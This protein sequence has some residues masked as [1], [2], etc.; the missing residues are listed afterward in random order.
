M[1]IT[2]HQ[3]IAHWLLGLRALL[4]GRLDEADGH[5]QVT[6]TITDR[7][8]EVFYRGRALLGRARAALMN[9]EEARAESLGHDG[10]DV[11]AGASDPLGV[12][13]ALELLGDVAAMWDSHVEAVRLAT[14]GDAIREACGGRRFPF[15]DASFEIVLAS[16]RDAMGEEAFERA[17]AEGAAMS[18]EEAVAYAARGRGERKRPSAGWESLTPT[19]LDVVRLAARGLSNPEI[20]QK[21]FI[22]RNTV[23]V[24]LSHVFSKLG[25]TSRAELAAEATRRRI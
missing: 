23:K 12:S 7:S 9:G 15:E 2:W 8:R 14:A 3:T 24:H 17:R 21:L 1:E 16:S 22:A 5:F 10:L 13:D 20:A 6:I 4:L 25:V 11:F 19:E 18:I